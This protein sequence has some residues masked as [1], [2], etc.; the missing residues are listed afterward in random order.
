[1]EKKE[2]GAEELFRVIM[3]EGRTKLMT[4]TKLQIQEAQR[5]PSRINNNKKNLHPHI[6]Y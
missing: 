2:K 5:T 1:M 4:G 3:A 6:S